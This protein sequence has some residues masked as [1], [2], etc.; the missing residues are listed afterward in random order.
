MGVFVW[1]RCSNETRYHPMES[2]NSGMVLHQVRSD[3]RS[4]SLT[5]SESLGNA[6]NLPE[7]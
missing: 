7:S 5:N 3:F 4:D 6:E 1:V 2:N